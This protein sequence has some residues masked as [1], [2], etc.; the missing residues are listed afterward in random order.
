MSE[1]FQIRKKIT[2]PGE[3]HVENEMFANGVRVLFS[4]PEAW[5][6]FF[7]TRPTAVGID[8]EGI[9]DMYK[10]GIGTLPLMIQVAST[11]I[12]IIEL[13][14][15]NASGDIKSQFSVELKSLLS[16][17]NVLKVFFDPVR[18]LEIFFVL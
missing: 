1:N 13:P 18:F 2:Q 11:S 5:Q 12:V 14:E 6:L 15:E 4:C 7:S 17:K 9:A 3:C 8:C 16:N 10:K